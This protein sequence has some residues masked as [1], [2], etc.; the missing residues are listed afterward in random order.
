MDE[1]DDVGSKS[2]QKKLLDDRN[3]VMI[4][5]IEEY[6]KGKEQCFVVVGSGHLIGDKGIVKL[7]EGKNYKVERVTPGSLGH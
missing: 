2:L 5:K 7:L 4:T 3:A 6:L 1:Q